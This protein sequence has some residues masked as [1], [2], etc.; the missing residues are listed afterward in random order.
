[1]ME[2]AAKK[3]PT[4]CSAVSVCV[5]ACLRLGY[6]ALLLVMSF[7]KPFSLFFL[8]FTFHRL[9]YAVFTL[10][11]S[12]SPSLSYF[13]FFSLLFP[14]FLHCSPFTFPLCSPSLFFCLFLMLNSSSNSTGQF[15]EKKGKSRHPSDRR[16]TFFCSIQRWSAASLL[17][18]S[19]LSRVDAYSML[20]HDPTTQ[21][22]Q[23]H[24]CT[25]THTRTFAEVA[26]RESRIRV[27]RGC[28]F[29][30]FKLSL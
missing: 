3:S 15:F 27:R 25:H 14:V 28:C 8:L 16:T 12:F 30:F 26:L 20:L 10:S 11:S 5:C 21:R 1:M 17:T 7:A 6:G 24:T 29:F 13:L 23:P 19:L 9:R 18:T 2:E 22:T 4:A